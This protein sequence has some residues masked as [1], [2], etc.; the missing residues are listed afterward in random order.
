MIGGPVLGG[1]VLGMFFP[2]TNS[3]VSDYFYLKKRQLNIV[4]FFKII[5]LR[6]LSQA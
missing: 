5:Y 4:K 2:W 3:I 1:F 6:E